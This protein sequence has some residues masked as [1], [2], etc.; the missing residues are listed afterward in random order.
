MLM[1][2]F[3]FCFFG[4]IATES[5]LAYADSVYES[6][7][8]RQPLEIQKSFIL[9][10]C[11]GN[12]RKFYQGFGIINLDLETFTKVNSSIIFDNDIFDIRFH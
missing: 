11:Y 7:W 1:N 9:M 6:K 12:R 5:L 8:Y 2:M 3:L 10:I 4:K